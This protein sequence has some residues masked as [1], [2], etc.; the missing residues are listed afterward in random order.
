MLGTRIPSGAS[1]SCS[2]D[3]RT[4]SCEVGGSGGRVG[5]RSTKREPSSRS[6]RKEKFEPPPSPIRRARNSPDPKPCSSR[7]LRTASSTI[8][9]GCL[10]GTPRS[11]Q[12]SRVDTLLVGG[13]FFESPRWHDGRWV[14]SDFVR[15]RV[16]TVDGDVVQVEG[17]PSGLGWLQDGSLLVVSMRDRRV[18]RLRDDVLELHADL[19]HLCDWHANDMVVTPD[20]GAY[21]GN[22]GFDLGNEKPRPTGLVHVD[23]D[24]S[25]QRV[26]E[27]LMFPNGLVF[28]DGSL[29]VGET[30]AAR[31]TEF[32]VE[33][34]GTLS[35]RR[36]FATV[37]GTAPDG[38][39]LDGEGCVWS[40][41]AL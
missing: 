26:A 30:Y 24:G 2:R 19:S 1:P 28:H 4:T 31:L 11:C 41:D 35:D 5:L 3:S 37:P 18:L 32:T 16:V 14:C 38:C 39:A 23:A 7:K 22:F 40:A 8:R 27:G 36:L 6:S 13:A 17:Q 21:V 12:H 33:P 29:I 34:D 10:V 20:G 15:R 25:A 9:G